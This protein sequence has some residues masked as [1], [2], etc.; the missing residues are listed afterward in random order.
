M[1]FLKTH[2]KT[3]ILIVLIL[4]LSGGAAYFFYGKKEDKEL[5]LYG[6]VDIRQISL[7][8]NGAERVEA[9]YK[10]EGD[11]VKEGEVLARLHTEALELSI[12]RAK[13]AI[14]GQEAVVAKLHNGTRKE[15]ILQARA[16][17]NS[18][19]AEADN[20]KRYSERMDYLLSQGAV[21]RQSAD[22]ARSR[23]QAAQ[24]NLENGKAYLDLALEGPRSEDI[25]AAEAQLEAL[26]AELRNYEYNL[27]NATLTAPQDGVVRS[28]L[29][30]PGDM[31]SPERAVYMID[32]KSVV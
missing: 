11:A 30:E 20:A 26:Q 6:N 17:M 25:R 1:E 5:V 4:L 21:S 7:A 22:D 8:F 24:A 23:S 12:A 16:Q 13:A 15:E 29:V 18:L 3:I 31:V 27:K 32:R 10:N 9:M 14:A 2:K 19:A 28:R